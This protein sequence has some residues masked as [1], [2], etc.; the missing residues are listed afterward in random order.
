MSVQLAA[1]EARDRERREYI[2]AIIRHVGSG[3]VSFDAQGRIATVNEAAARIL[4]MPPDSLVGRSVPE[5]C[6]TIPEG[7]AAEVVLRSVQPLLDGR[8]TKWSARSTW[9]GRRTR[10]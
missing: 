6:R 8:Q 10:S 4:A 2:E 1:S 3:V 5:A 9:R 7:D